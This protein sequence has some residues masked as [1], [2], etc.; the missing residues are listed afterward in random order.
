MRLRAL[1]PA[2]IPRLVAM[3]RAPEAAGRASVQAVLDRHA[4]LLDMALREAPGKPAA[5]APAGESP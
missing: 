1:V 4:T 3:E 5:P 2:E